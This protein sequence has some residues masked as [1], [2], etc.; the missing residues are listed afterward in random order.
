MQLIEICLLEGI[1][2]DGFE[3][4]DIKRVLSISRIVATSDVTTKLNQE[5]RNENQSKESFEELFQEAKNVKHKKEVV[6]NQTMNLE[7][8]ENHYILY[9][10]SAHEIAWQSKR[11]QY[12][13]QK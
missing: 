13:K 11:S 7:D 5:Q 12:N 9:D 2:A 3:L 4:R 10:R 6:E 8:F 1:T